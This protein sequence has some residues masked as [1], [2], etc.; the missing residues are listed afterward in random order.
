MN[1][2]LYKKLKDIRTRKD[3]TL[4]PTKYLKSTFTGFD[5]EEHQLKLRYYQIQGI[6]H[7]ACMRR[8]LLGD[9]CGL[10]KTIQSIT[11][12]CFLWE[13][14]PKLKGL[15]LTLDSYYLQYKLDF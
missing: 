14:D 8:F 13:Q 6:L 11:A 2:K 4:R 7:L 10:G 5:G 9:D 1:D 12:L 3:L 15:V